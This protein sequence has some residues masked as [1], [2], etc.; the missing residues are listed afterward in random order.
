MTAAEQKAWI[1]GR[2]AAADKAQRMAESYTRSLSHYPDDDPQYR[3][4]HWCAT[5]ASLAAEDIRALTP[6]AATPPSMP[7]LDEVITHYGID[8]LCRALA[9]EIVREAGEAPATDWTPPEDREDL[10]RC[11]IMVPATWV[12]WDKGGGV[13]QVEDTDKD[14]SDCV[15]ISEH[16]PT[17]FAPLP[18]VKP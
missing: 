9:P 2:D 11:Q 10:F 3:V 17:A 14:C 15:Y 5:A 16:S 4:I 6:P 12:A 1:A 7:P 18:G 13:W 8:A